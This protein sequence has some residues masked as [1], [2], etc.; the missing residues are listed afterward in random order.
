MKCNIEYVGKLRNG[1]PQYYCTT[2]K[3]FA[4]DKKGNRLEE[5]LCIE[6]D[7]FDNKLNIKEN[8]VKNLKIV[9]SN[10]LENTKPDIFIND[11]IFSGVLIYDN[12]ILNYKDLG[13]IMLS[14][15]NSISL[16]KVKCN[17]C[18][19]YHSDNGKFAYTLHRTHLCLYCG[20]LFRAKDK[21]IGNE[22]T[23]I[24]NIPDMQLEDK[25]ISV[26]SNCRVEYD[27][28]KGKL[29]VNNKN[30]N[31]ILISNKKIKIIDFLNNILQNEY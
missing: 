13:G 16:E 17:N 18:G 31:E 9:Y 23:I 8:S 6:K 4:S 10:I 24:F 22:L 27:I 3:S 28:L 30:V 14:K 29:L 11:K 21:N 12:C 25:M 15:L 5:C 1:I 19:K 26:E 7:L 20:H 2:H